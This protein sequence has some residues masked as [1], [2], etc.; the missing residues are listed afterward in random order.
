MRIVPQPSVDEVYNFY[1]YKVKG[2]KVYKC[3]KIISDYVRRNKKDL[4]FNRLRDTLSFLPEKELYNLYC[5]LL[6]YEK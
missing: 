6:N 2:D 1:L 5:E 4:N 3:A